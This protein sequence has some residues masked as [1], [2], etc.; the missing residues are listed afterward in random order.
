[1][2]YEDEHLLVVDKPSGLL[3]VPG[4]SGLL[5]DSVATRLRARYPEATGSLVTHRLDLDTSGLLLAAKDAATGSALMRLFSLRQV[6]KRYIAWVEGHVA[7][8]PA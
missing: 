8:T 5:R 7:G 3:S 4:R 6:T 1:M 2:V